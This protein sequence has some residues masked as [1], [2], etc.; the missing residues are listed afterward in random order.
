MQIEKNENPRRWEMMIT[1]PGD[2]HEQMPTWGG[3]RTIIRLRPAQWLIPLKTRRPH[4][5]TAPLP[6]HKFVTD[7]VTKTRI[8]QETRGQDFS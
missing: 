5:E 2:A 7:S 3:R 8:G 6:G 1:V 4:T